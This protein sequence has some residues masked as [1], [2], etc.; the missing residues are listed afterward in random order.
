M[1]GKPAVP[2]GRGVVVL[3]IEVSLSSSRLPKHLV[4]QPWENFWVK[5]VPELDGGW[6]YHRGRTGNKSIK[7]V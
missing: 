1:Y 6:G 2:E 4:D 3:A 5:H 7:D